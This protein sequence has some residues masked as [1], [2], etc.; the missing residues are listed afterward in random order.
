MRSYLGVL[1]TMLV[2]VMFTTASAGADVPRTLDADGVLV[3]SWIAPVQVEIFCEPQC[4]YCA[5]MEATDGDKLAAAVAGG[6]L[7]IT[8]R[9]LTFLNA[10][11][12]ND[13]STRLVNAL[14][15]AADPAAAPPAYQAFVRDLY[16]HQSKDGPTA[17]E[18]AAMAR[19][20]GLPDVV[21]DRIAAGDDAVDAVAVGDANKARL[22]EEN[23]AN[24]GTPTIYNLNTRSVV[25]T[26][27]PGWLDALTG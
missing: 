14:F 18:V 8:Y 3:G 13:V 20:S 24:P 22:K 7:A 10:R 23:P 26:D 9:W 4:P 1:L 16:R 25:D 11:H 15:L 2:S 6:R 21:A 12:H 5:E 19:E 17:D 27:D